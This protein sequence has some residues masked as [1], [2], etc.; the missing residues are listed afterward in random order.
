VVDIFEEV[1]EDLR[2]ERA[3]QLWKKYGAYVIA[4]AVALVV[5]TGAYTYWRDYDRKSREAEGARF[6]AA[7]D[8][9]NQG[10]PAEAASSFAEIAKDGRAGYAILAK[11]QEAGLKTRGGDQAGAAAIYRAIAGDSG[12]DR[13]FRDAATVLT[14]MNMQESGNPAELARM[15]EPLQA[16]GNPWRHTALELGAVLAAKAGDRAKAREIYARLADDP[17]TPVSLRGRAAEMLQ[18]LGG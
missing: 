9:A 11:F 5:G 1:N 7:M 3:A 14:V 17:A 16:D 12:A 15:L 13:E 8:L 4:G 6:V 10:K 2:Q 18:A